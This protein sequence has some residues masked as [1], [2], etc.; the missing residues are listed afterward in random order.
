MKDNLEKYFKNNKSEFDFS[1]PNI[2]HFERFEAR[3]KNEIKPTKKSVKTQW[4]WLAIAASFLLFF[5][6]WMG[7]KDMSKGL[8][9]A[10]VS[11]KM[12]ETQNF[13]AA[14]IHKEIEIIQ[15]QRTVKNQVII[16]DALDQL[17]I[18]EKNYINLKV[19]LKES[20]E[21]KR[22]IFAMISNY[23]KRLEVLQNLLDQLEDFKN[24]QELNPN[25]I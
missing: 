19:E 13:Y 10:D 9:L 3:L 6:Y 11:Q 24:Y 5:G 25:E 23:Q 22:V 7:N 14:S 18:L 1:E 4:H 21:D 15:N 20:N 16:D 8:E 2:G 17:K 12:E